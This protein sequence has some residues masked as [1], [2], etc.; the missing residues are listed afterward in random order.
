MG[1]SGKTK[2]IGSVVRWLTHERPPS[3]IPMSDYERTRYEIKPGDVILVEG[4][5]RVSDV[6]KAITQSCWSHAALYI[7]RVHEIEDPLMRQRVKEY[8]DGQ[9]DVQLIIESELGYGT[10]VRPLSAYDRGPPENL[11]PTRPNIP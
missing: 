3:P 4:R 11:P 9:P 8:F 10:I 5:T 2:F 7:G 6:I 1:L